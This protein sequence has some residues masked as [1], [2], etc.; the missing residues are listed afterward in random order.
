MSKPLFIPIISF[1]FFYSNIF[2]QS[3]RD[4]SVELSADVQNNPPRIVLN[5]TAN[6]SATAYFVYRKPKAASLWGP[7]IATLPGTATQYIDTTVSLA[8][9]YE[10]QIIRQA[11]AFV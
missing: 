5:W 8:V 2:S 3:C 9:S 10:Y 7:L 11:N 1:I 4:A 6:D